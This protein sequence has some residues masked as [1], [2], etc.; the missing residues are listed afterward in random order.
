MVS[1]R[2]G[3][4][5]HTRQTRSVTESVVLS[6]TSAAAIL[7]AGVAWGHV[8]GLYVGLLA[9]TAATAAQAAWLWHRSAPVLRRETQAL[10]KA[11][12]P[13]A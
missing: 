9:F 7:I 3:I 13:A 12:Q 4:L 8:A 6:L 11:P 2:Q 10:P 5:V 1:W